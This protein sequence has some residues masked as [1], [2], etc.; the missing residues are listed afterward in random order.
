MEDT[1][2]QQKQQQHQEKITMWVESFSDDLYS[3]AL[4]KTN[5]K[6]VAE[7]LVQDT[8]FAAFKS[9]D[10][11]REESTAKTWIFKILNNKII[12]HYRKSSRFKKI[13][14]HNEEEGIILTNGL[15][16]KHNNWNPNGLED[17]WEQDEHLLDNTDFNK[18]MSLCMDDLP[19]PWRTAVSWKYYLEREA[20]EICQELNITPSNYWQI[21]HRAKLLLKKCLEKNWFGK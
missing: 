6:L 5:D 17:K 20:G 13:S 3:W 10:S 12:D 1:Q 16:D 21:I 18:I 11:F 8:F 15:F 4:Y 7:D 9:L 2:Q 14:V 19:T